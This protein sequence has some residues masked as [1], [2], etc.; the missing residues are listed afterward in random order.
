MTTTGPGRSQMVHSRCLPSHANDICAHR[1]AVRS[2]TPRAGQHRASPPAHPHR[3]RT[4]H[5]AWCAPMH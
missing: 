3:A 5:R 1:A 4:A 2:A